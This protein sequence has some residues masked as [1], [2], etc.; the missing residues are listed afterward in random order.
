MFVVESVLFDCL[1]GCS[2][3]EKQLSVYNDKVWTCQCTGHINLTHEE[4][5]NSEKAVLKVVKSQFAKSYEKT[6]LEIVHHS[7]FLNIVYLL[8]VI[9]Y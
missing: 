2:E 7:K 8:F 3:Y 1:N 9:S 4:A 5:W 6:V